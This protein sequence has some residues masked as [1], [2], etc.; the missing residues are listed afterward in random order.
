ML[1]HVSPTAHAAPWLFKRPLGGFARSEGDEVGEGK[2]TGQSAFFIR[3]VQ[4]DADVEDAVEIVPRAISKLRRLSG[5]PE[6]GTVS[7]T[8]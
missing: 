3:S 4:F 8:S 2:G 5:T 7:V 6:V 1:G